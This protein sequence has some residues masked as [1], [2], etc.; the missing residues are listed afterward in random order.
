MRLPFLERR[1]QYWSGMAL[2][3]LLL[4]LSAMSG[5][6]LLGRHTWNQHPHWPWSFD[7]YGADDAALLCIGALLL[8][9]G[10]GTWLRAKRALQQFEQQTSHGSLELSRLP[11]SMCQLLLTVASADG[12]VDDVERVRIE[13]VLVAGAGQRLLHSDVKG[14]LATLE[15][16]ADAAALAREVGRRMDENRRRELFGWC[17]QVALADGGIDEDERYVL[18]DIA[19]GLQLPAAAVRR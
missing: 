16:A 11:R 13:E 9:G 14:W 3:G 6:D 15:P 7:E 8:V 2:F 18:A 17:Q 4:L 5:I 19:R 1:E 12:R 10:G